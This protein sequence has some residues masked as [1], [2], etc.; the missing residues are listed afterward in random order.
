MAEI[1]FGQLEDLEEKGSHHLPGF[2]REYGK[3]IWGF[4]C[5][6][7]QM[8]S[9]SRALAAGLG[10]SEMTFVKCWAWRGRSLDC[11]HMGPP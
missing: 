2:S 11:C 8:T 10:Q 5:P 1:E 9:K 4:I 3:H 6:C 7:L